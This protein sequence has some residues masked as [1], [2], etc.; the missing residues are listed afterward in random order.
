MTAPTTVPLTI[1]EEAAERLAELGMHAEFERMLEHTRQ[2]VPGLRAMRVAIRPVYDTHEDTGITIEAIVDETYR[3]EDRTWWQW[4]DWLHDTFPPHV[5]E[6]FSMTP[7]REY[8]T[9]HAG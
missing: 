4:Q 6:H 2:T 9:D 7:M 1:T 5:F 8:G 3:P